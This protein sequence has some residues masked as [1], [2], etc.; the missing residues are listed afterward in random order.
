MHALEGH[1]DF[2]RAG[3]LSPSSPHLF[4]TGSYDHTVKLWDIGANRCVMTLRHVA[5]VMD[6]VVL[7]GGG[8]LATASGTC[9]AVSASS[10]ASS[11]GS[12]VAFSFNSC[13]ILPKMFAVTC[14]TEA[15]VHGFCSYLV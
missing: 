5:P 7:P 1:T 14:S 13:C 6:L 3:A 2:V 12:G 9:F 11:P 15:P 4:A 10:K 8:M